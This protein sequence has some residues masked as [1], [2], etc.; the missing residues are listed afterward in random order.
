MS[1]RK[2]VRFARRLHAAIRSPGILQS[3]LTTVRVVTGTVSAETFIVQAFRQRGSDTV[4]L[5]HRDESGVTRLVI[6]PAVMK[7]ITRHL[8]ARRR[9]KAAVPTLGKRRAK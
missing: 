1:E 8:D 5:W 6:P 9:R 7:V 3:P 4:F 2:A